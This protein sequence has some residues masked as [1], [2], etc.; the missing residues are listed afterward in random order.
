ML[1]LTVAL[2]LA[3]AGHAVTVFEAAPTL[4]GLASAWTI[5]TADGELRWDRHYH[6]TLESDAALRAL[7][8]DLGLDDD[9]AV[10]DDPTGYFAD[11]RL[12]P[13]STP[14]R[15]PRAARALADREGPARA[16]ARARGRRSRTGARSS[17]CRSSGG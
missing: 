11:G 10:D 16:D 2:R 8:T 5:P 6:V 17:G 4:G 1:G 12:S 7:L 13:V 15:V 9:V 3:E 14:R